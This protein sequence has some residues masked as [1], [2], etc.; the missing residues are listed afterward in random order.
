MARRASSAGRPCTL[1][2]ANP[3]TGSEVVAVTRISSDRGRKNSCFFLVWLFLAVLTL[4]LPGSAQQISDRK[5]G[6]RPCKVIDSEAAAGKKSTKQQK[7]N[8]G[9]GAT[10]SGTGCLEVRSSTLAVQ[11]NLQAFVRGQKWRAGDEEIGESFLSFSVALSKGE[12]LGYTT[13]DSTTER[14]Q[15]RSGKAVVLVRTS[16]LSDGYTRTIVRAHFEGF[17]DSDDSF[18]M[19]RASWTLSSNGRLEATLIEALQAHFRG[20]Q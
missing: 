5:W 4:T 18:A 20:D 15:W 13:L 8:A 6:V 9:Q 7:R 14:V 17:G 11:E 1:S 19:K 2:I 3:V 12:L 10:S 16:E